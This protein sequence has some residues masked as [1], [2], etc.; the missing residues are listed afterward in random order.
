M[1]TI[2]KRGL[3]GLLAL[4][5]VLSMLPVSA[6]AEEVSESE[7][8]IVTE[9]PETAPPATETE[10]EALT[11]EATEA[12]AIE[13]EVPETEPDET[14]VPVMEVEQIMADAPMAYVV[15]DFIERDIQ[16]PRVDMNLDQLPGDEDR[17]I[18]TEDELIDDGIKCI[19]NY[20]GK[21][22]PNG[23][24]VDEV[25]GDYKGFDG[26]WLA[27]V[28]EFEGIAENG[29][30]TIF[31]ENTTV[32]INGTQCPTELLDEGTRIRATYVYMLQAIEVYYAHL[33]IPAPVAGE[34]AV[35]EAEY[36]S[37]TDDRYEI[38]AGEGISATN[39]IRWIVGDSQKALKPGDKFESG[40]YY[41]ALIYIKAGIGCRF[42]ANMDATVSGAVDVYV[43]SYYSTETY[44]QY[45]PDIYRVVVAEFNLEGEYDIYV[46]NGFAYSQ[47]GDLIGFAK[48]GDI[49]T[50]KPGEPPK[51][52]I[53]GIENWS[54][55]GWEVVTPDNS[56][57]VEEN[58]DTLAETTIVMP[59]EPV[60]VQC[61]FD[62]TEVEEV[63]LSLG[64]YG[65]G[66]YVECMTV[67]EDADGA[68]LGYV[69]RYGTNYA[70]YDGPKGT[71]N[72]L[73]PAGTV[74]EEG[75]T[76]WLKVTLN[77]VPGYSLDGIYFAYYYDN[78]EYIKLDGVAAKE[79]Y[80]NDDGSLDVA[81]LLS[82]PTVLPTGKITVENGYTYL[83][84][85]S[86]P[87]QEAPAGT[88]VWLSSVV[89]D[90]LAET[91]WFSHWVIVKGD[92]EID[93]Y[94]PHPGFVMPEGDVEL[95]A[96]FLPVIRNVYV[97]MDLPEAGETPV[98]TAES[99]TE[100]VSIGEIIWTKSAATHEEDMDP[101]EVLEYE[102]GYRVQIEL[103]VDDEHTFADAVEGEFNGEFFGASL[104][105][106]GRWFLDYYYD[107]GARKY[108][109]TVDGGYAK[110]FST[111]V[112]TSAAAGEAILVEAIIP[113]GC[114]F[115]HW[116]VLKGD[117]TIGW[118]DVEEF[119]FT[120]P[121]E[122]V[123]FK[124]VFTDL[125]NIPIMIV[126]GNG[127]DLNPAYDY[128]TQN[129]IDMLVRKG[130][131]SYYDQ[132]G[133]VTWTTSSDA[134]ATVERA[135]KNYWELVFHK[136]GTVTVTA[137]DAYGC[138]DSI[139]ITGY[140]VDAAKKFTVTSDV[141]SIGL[142]VGERARM[143]IFGTDKENELSPI[144]FEY[145]VSKE[146]IV[147]VHEGW[148]SGIAPG[149]ATITAKLMN[150]PAGRKVTL[151]VKV[152]EPQIENICV[153]YTC[154]NAVEEET[155]WLDES[156]SYTVLY[157]N[158]EDFA[159][160]PGSITLTPMVKNTQGNELTL[161]KSLLKWKSSNTKV[162]KLKV[163][164]DG[165]TT[166][167]IP[168][169]AAGI[170]RITLTA[171]D[172]A[173]TE[174]IFV[175]HVRD[176]A[177]KLS[178]KKFTFDWWKEDPFVPMDLTE[179]YDN[180][181]ETVTVHEYV[182]GLRDYSPDESKN[183]AVRRDTNTGAY[184]IG[185]TDTATLT[186]GTHKLSMKV[187]C[188]NDK[189]YSFLISATIQNKQPKFT[190]VQF[191]PLNIFYNDCSAQLGSTFTLDGDAPLLEKLE[192]SENNQNKDITLENGNTLVLTEECINRKDYNIDRNIVLKVKLFGYKPFDM[193]YK[194][195]TERKY[196][197]LVADPGVLMITQ[198][199]KKGTLKFKILD[200]DT[201][202]NYSSYFGREEGS[203]CVN[204]GTYLTVWKYDNGTPSD[205]SDDYLTVKLTEDFF[206]FGE[207]RADIY[208]Y[209][210]NL[211]C[212]P[213]YFEVTVKYVKELPKVSLSEKTLNLNSTFTQRTS[214]AQVSISDY[215]LNLSDLK[216][217]FACTDKGGSAAF[218]Q[219]QKI[220]LT[221]QPGYGVV[222]AFKD[223][224]DLPTAGS[225]TFAAIPEVNGVT[226]PKVSI[227]V[228]VKDD[229][230][231]LSIDHSTVKLNK[232]LAGSEVF[233]TDCF[234]G[235]SDLQL[236]GFKEAGNAYVNISYSD[237]QLH[238]KLKRADAA[239]KYT[240]QL[241]PKVKDLT[242]GQIVYSPNKLKLTVQTYKNEKLAI[243]MASTGKL[244]TIVPGSAMYFYVK[245]VTNA[246][247]T[248]K[249]IRLEGADAER[250]NVSENEYSEVLLTL[251]EDQTY[252]TKQAYQIKFVY[253]VCGKEVTSAVMKIKV[254]Q[255]KVKA[256]IL[257]KTTALYLNSRLSKV[258]ILNF[259]IKL[260]TPD[261]AKLDAGSIKL[262]TSKTT[263][264][265]RRALGS[266]NV[267]ISEDGTTAKVSILVKNPGLLDSGKKYTIAFNVMPV[268]NASNVKPV[269][270]TATVLTK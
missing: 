14:E 203:S 118:P 156:T 55:S 267:E 90:E 54:F 105:E 53:E 71:P 99:L 51:E 96:V 217:N 246:A 104:T 82:A 23:G 97:T 238:A 181:I 198:A 234:Y 165:S 10:T 35:F 236:L 158:A 150:D 268:G 172:K 243:T 185:L 21:T 142:Q 81:F 153:S 270:V 179:S 174:Q 209:K 42:A 224:N 240:F 195:K 154:V 182:K 225:Y 215:T 67:T 124:A 141:P 148:I 88:H 138:K 116:E 120:M 210:D 98:Y 86:E 65:I 117:V 85:S 263:L 8:T 183:F 140:Y 1:K 95:K 264:A 103:I 132:E 62:V 190:L 83:N 206:S 133:D 213:L 4:C 59:A 31:D 20:I 220:S 5:M 161:T 253:E 33:D 128:S 269:T 102:M 230:N 262:N 189:T 257:P 184:S 202:E 170:A 169:K 17:F 135:A 110:Y 139:K 129:R 26:Q 100:G 28:L 175:L 15:A 193:N 134:I 191:N 122:D 57:F 180:T 9:E 258:K 147:E 145:T 247:G 136:P 178:T 250:F 173:K 25:P 164:A 50:L 130:Q 79:I 121:A 7:E 160:A 221:Y 194:V 101:N 72:S 69:P 29:V 91:H 58:G 70:I 137:T 39:G 78:A 219:A 87:I 239:A 114:I 171:N 248:P 235:S 207:Y 11:T 36:A 22:D 144:N 204:N 41:K 192:L 34:E 6:F 49:V 212:G 93:I 13:T 260:T 61:I 205:R 75:E 196:P 106:E 251:K 107:T 167:T 232:Y 188:S 77:P 131:S 32:V 216:L 177:P 223:P 45:D 266:A 48:P 146:G 113:E 211:M 168:R 37:P 186:K 76:Y 149:T 30:L 241:T 126:D 89:P 63:N 233:S 214:V 244:D 231:K 151:K 152:I 237:G 162:A 111:E 200:R 256:S 12:E 68:E 222:A 16:L 261:G 2:L 47:D 3:S 227:K 60:H 24:Y 255:S 80:L 226:L 112:I 229:T 143:K 252:S 84:T 125:K 73:L 40:H 123:A 52:D 109:I 201:G 197:F 115:D 56:I 27:A 44:E 92:V 43:S 176:Y 187:I 218:V 265:M 163:N 108:S 19:R 74:I 259:T 127:G 94:E 228:S 249:F 159:D 119:E 46:E 166:V 199:N 254:T 64:G 38:G 155:V 208:A 18:D 66:S 242:T 157:V 245:K